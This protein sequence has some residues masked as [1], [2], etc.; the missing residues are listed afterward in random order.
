MAFVLRKA[1]EEV[2][3]RALVPYAKEKIV[4]SGLSTIA[5]CYLFCIF[6]IFYVV[7]L[8]KVNYQSVTYSAFWQGNLVLS[9]LIN[10]ILM[11]K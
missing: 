11:V 3:E 1:A 6:I 10:Y 4:E 8:T 2:T 5:K 9:P 7:Y